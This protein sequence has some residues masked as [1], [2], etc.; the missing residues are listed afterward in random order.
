MA[1][2]ILKR[3]NLA[4]LNNLAIEDGQFILV[5]DEAAIYADIGTERIRFGD[6]IQVADV[7]SLP[8]SGANTKALYYAVSENVLCRFSGTEWIQIN[9]QPTAEEMKTLLGL[10]LLAYKSTVAE[11]DL[12][13]ALAEKVNA[14]SEGNHAHLNKDELDKVADGDVEKWNTA[15]GLAGTAVQPAA[16]EDMATKTGQKE[17]TDALSSRVKAIEDLGLEA[18]STYAKDADLDA[19]VERV[20]ALETA[21]GENGS[22]ATQ[23]TNA[24]NELDVD[25]VAVGAGETLLSVS[26]TDGK[27]AV[28]KQNIAI[29]ASQVTDFA[30]EVAKVEVTNASNAAKLNNRTDTEIEASA[31][32]TAN[33]N[34]KTAIEALDSSITATEGSFLTGIT[35]EDGKIVAKTEATPV[36]QTDYTV[37]MAASDVEGLAKRYTFTQCGEEIGTIDLAKELVVTSGSVKEV[38]EV[39]V[40]YTGAKVGEKYIEL[41]IA[42]QDEPI[43]VPAKDLVDIYTAKADAT[44]VQVAISNTNEISAT[45]VNGGIEEAHLAADVKTKLNYTYDDSDLKNRVKAIEDAPYATEGYVNTAVTDMATNAGQKLITDALS[46]RIDALEADPV[47]KNYVD[48][49]LDKKLDS[50]G[51]VLTEENFTTVLKGKLE[52]ISAG[53]NKVEA[54]TNG[55]IK[56]DG[57]D[58]VVYAPDANTVIDGE[59][60]HI[61]VTETSVSDGTNT[62]NKYVHHT[63][64]AKA[65]SFVKVGNDA[66][67]HVVLGDAI[68]QKDITDLIGTEVYDAK[69][70]AE[71]KILEALTWGEF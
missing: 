59:Y 69:G 4:G 27:I 39:D 6:F 1:N 71:I 46:N 57:V 15:A 67:G 64:E 49:E 65:A 19:A 34:T 42:N 3:G 33:D 60:K 35:I 68:V 54:S 43:Y 22:V 10:G 17:I 48:T 23:I 38:T 16:I 7:A 70:T 20:S 31:V 13:T 51:H 32:A 63:Q 61:T 18:G 28:T 25:A 52:G 8:V 12:D 47:T 58:T 11:A 45:L 5:R 56:I 41:V 40:P 30:T 26:E 21:I 36:A 37:T 53:A 44:Q 29:T 66:E 24:I 50:E 14:A 62:F 2:L 9:K 55:K